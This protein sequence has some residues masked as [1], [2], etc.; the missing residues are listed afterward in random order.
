MKILLRKK[1][2]TS[3]YIIPP[4]SC[5]SPKNF[6][7]VIEYDEI[8]LQGSRKR[9][10]ESKMVLNSNGGEIFMKNTIKLQVK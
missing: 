7:R 4:T 2:S 1:H 10:E 9:I 5:C 8:L 3:I 6:E